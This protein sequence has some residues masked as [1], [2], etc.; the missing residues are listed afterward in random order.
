MHASHHRAR[1]TQTNKASCHHTANELVLRPASQRARPM[2][3]TLQEGPTGRTSCTRA[4]SLRPPA[5]EPGGPGRAHRAPQ[6]RRRGAGAVPEAQRVLGQRRERAAGGRGLRPLRAPPRDGWPP[7]GSG[8]VL[9]RFTSTGWWATLHVTLMRRPVP[10]RAAHVADADGPGQMMSEVNSTL[11]D[12]KVAPCKY[13]LVKETAPNACR[14]LPTP[15]GLHRARPA[16]EGQPQQARRIQ[17]PWILPGSAKEGVWTLSSR[18]C[19]SLMPSACRPAS[20]GS[21]ASRSQIRPAAA[22]S[23]APG[24]RNAQPQPA[25]SAAAAASEPPM[26]PTLVCAF[27]R[28]MMA[29]R[30]PLLYLQRGRGRSLFRHAQGAQ[31]P[32]ARVVRGST[33][34]TEQACQ[35]DPPVRRAP[36]RRTQAGQ[37]LLGSL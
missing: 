36:V 20:S 10:A 32:P 15:A 24:A 19:S 25:V 21:A 28:P 13:R 1:H 29:P 26:L 6:Q 4:L 35:R 33:K 37:P 23:A 27:H 5:A 17:D 34:M 12:N 22:I 31:V 18:A 2:T 11:S 3:A 16:H 30:R 7:G 14:C 9:A 8:R